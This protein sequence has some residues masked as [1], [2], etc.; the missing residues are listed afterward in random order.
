MWLKGNN[1]DGL[2]ASVISF[3]NNI[4]LTNVMATSPQQ[5]LFCPCEQIIHTLTPLY[6]GHLFIPPPPPLF[7]L[8]PRWL[9]WKGST[10]FFTCWEH[11]NKDSL[12]DSP[13]HIDISKIMHVLIAVNFA[14]IF[15]WLFYHTTFF[16]INLQERPVE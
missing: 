5:P 14:L 8:F 15:S 10:V 2:F 7:L 13:W 1:I 6:N 3:E 16:F 9:L 11:L 4:T 12:Q